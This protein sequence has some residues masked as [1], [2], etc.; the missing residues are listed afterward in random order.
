SNGY[1]NIAFVTL[2]SLQSQMVDRLAGYKKATQDHDYA[3]CILE[4][5]YTLSE[6]VLVRQIKYYFQTQPQIDAVIFATNYL[7]VNGIR[8]LQE[9]EKEIPQQV[10]VIGF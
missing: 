4:I 10:A 8:A 7:A 3:P 6:E 5:A 1:K 2:S 9:L